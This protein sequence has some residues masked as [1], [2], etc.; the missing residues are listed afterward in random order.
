MRTNIDI[1]DTVLDAAMKAGSFRTKK[2]AV[3]AGLRLLA[4]QAIYRDLL[5]LQGKL[6]W[7]GD[8]AEGD[9][10]LGV[11]E[12]P[13]AMGVEPPKSASAAASKS[14]RV[15]KTAKPVKAKGKA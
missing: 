3:E 12:V 14:A 10:P 1:D 6:V 5:A 7:D 8:A 9:L 4:R 15:R 13:A 2:E 11:E